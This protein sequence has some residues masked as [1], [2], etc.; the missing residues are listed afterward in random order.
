MPITDAYLNTRWHHGVYL[1]GC[2]ERVARS[3]LCLANVRVAVGAMNAEL[4]Q[5][6]LFA[7]VQ[8]GRKQ[9]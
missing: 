5:P 4:S 2:I 8:S 1:C 9:A 6:D 7:T 3:G